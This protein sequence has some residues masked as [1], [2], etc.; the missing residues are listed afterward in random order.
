MFLA[1]TDK[2]RYEKRMGVAGKDIS[3]KKGDITNGWITGL[4]S[5]PGEACVISG[6]R[7]GQH[8]VSAAGLLIHN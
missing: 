8:K 3:T 4:G 5:C 2:N 7:A 6:F 1:R